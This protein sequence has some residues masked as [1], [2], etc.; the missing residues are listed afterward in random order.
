MRQELSTAVNKLIIEYGHIMTH[1]W[2]SILFIVKKL[3]DLHSL[4][5][6][7][8]TFLERVSPFLEEVVDIIDKVERSLADPNQ[9]YLCLTLIW[10]MGDHAHRHSHSQVQRKIYALLLQ[11]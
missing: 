7:V 9:K 8:E 1:G 5:A 3:G 6:I 2:R 11:P 10:Q 4:Q